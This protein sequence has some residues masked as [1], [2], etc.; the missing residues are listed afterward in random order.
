M[1]ECGAGI[2]TFG[3]LLLR[4]SAMPLS[5]NM[6]IIKRKMLECPATHKNKMFCLKARCGIP[7]F[8]KEIAYFD[9]LH[10]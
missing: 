5:Q 3:K 2:G 7:D 1:D 10:L 4:H 8:G 9:L 6:R